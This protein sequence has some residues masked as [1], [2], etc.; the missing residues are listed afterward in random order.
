M[1]LGRR[2]SL[3][4]VASIAIAINAAQ[5]PDTPDWQAAAGGKMS[6]EVASV[7]A[8]D[9]PR[10]V[11]D[12]PLDNGDE[13]TPGG[14]FSFSFPLTAYISFAYKLA[15]SEGQAMRAEFAEMVRRFLRD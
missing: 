14:R 4:S 15:P 10:T 1:S 13:K 2:L 11:P 6:F 5:S 12:F 8:G 9:A 7:K 3:L